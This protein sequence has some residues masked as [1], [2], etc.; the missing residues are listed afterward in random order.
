MTR[1]EQKKILDDEIE[2]NVNQYKIDRLN[3]EI[4]AFSS[5]DLNKYEFLTRKVL[6]YKPNALDKARFE[7]SPLRKAFSTGL[8]KT[9]QGYQEED[10][11]KLLKDIRDGIRNGRN[12]LDDGGDGD[13]GDGGDGGDD[14]LNELI[15]NKN[16][17][18]QDSLNQEKELQKGMYAL[19]DLFSA[20][21]KKYKDKNKELQDSFRKRIRK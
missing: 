14:N 7:F 13:N 10:V 18:L 16:K 19:R 21:N 6:K 11:I 2:S 15:N 4:S 12:G 9:V 1:K 3:A 8:D 5:G 20:E 17:E